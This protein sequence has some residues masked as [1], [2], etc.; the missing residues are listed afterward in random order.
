MNEFMVSSVARG[1]VDHGSPTP[2]PNLP[3]PESIPFS[4]D[5]PST[6]YITEA[7][8]HYDE[9]IGAH[10]L[11]VR[12]FHPFLRDPL[13]TSR[14]H[15]VLHY[16]AYGGSYIKKHKASPDAWAQL[17]KQLAFY[18]MHGR[19]PVVYESAQTRK[20]LLGRTEVLRSTSNEGKAWVEAMEDPKETVTIPQRMAR[21]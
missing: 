6:K 1:T 5:G 3:T 16:E 7:V 20:F 11:H 2:R 13:L 19:V 12:P 15:Q 9:L 10:D 21:R 4:L 8:Q 14:I 18:R 17:V